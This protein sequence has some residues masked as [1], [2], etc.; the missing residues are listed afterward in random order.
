MLLPP[1]D[2]NNAHLLHILKDLWFF[3]KHSFLL[4]SLCVGQLVVS[5]DDKYLHIII[6]S[7]DENGLCSCSLPPEVGHRLSGHI[8]TERQMISPEPNYP[9]VFCISPPA[10]H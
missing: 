1:D 6:L 4:Y 2:H 5:V 7:Q 3:R 8:H 9:P 10:H